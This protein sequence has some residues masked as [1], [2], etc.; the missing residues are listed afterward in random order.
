MWPFRAPDGQSAIIAQLRAELDDLSESYMGVV[1]AKS[2]AEIAMRNM[3]K[4]L[5]DDGVGEIAAQVAAEIADIYAS[6]RSGGV[7]SRDL[8]VH[9]V[10]AEAVRKAARGEKHWNEGGVAAAF[11][12]ARK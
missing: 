3:Q 12:K 9:A 10:V 11:R 6:G 8:A 5:T 2:D 7:Q 4:A 1:S